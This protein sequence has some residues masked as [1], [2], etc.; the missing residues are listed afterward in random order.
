MTREFIETEKN[1]LLQVFSKDEKQN[2]SQAEKNEVKKLVEVLKKEAA[3]NWR[4]EHE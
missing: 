2:L 3:D 4:K 1:Y